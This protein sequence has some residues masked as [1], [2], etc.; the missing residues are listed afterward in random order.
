MAIEQHMMDSIFMQGHRF[1]DLLNYVDY[2]DGIYCL[3]DGSLGKIWVIKPVSCEGREGEFLETLSKNVEQLIKSL[4][5]GQLAC[6]FIVQVCRDTHERQREYQCY[7][8]LGTVDNSFMASKLHHLTGLARD[9]Q[10]LVT[11]RYFPQWNRKSWLGG[12]QNIEFMLKNHQ[13]DF[14][15]IFLHME[16]VLL[17]AQIIAVE[18]NQDQLVHWL[19]RVLNPRRSQLIRQLT[20]SEDVSLRE[21][22]LFNEP[23]VTG[24]GLIVEGQHMRVISLKEL[25]GETQPG[26]F[27]RELYEGLR[28]C[29]LDSAPSMMMVINLTVP[30]ASESINRLNWHKSFAFMHQNNWLGDKSIEVQEKKKELDSTIA[31]L[32]REGERIVHA[33]CHVIIVAPGIDELQKSTDVLINAFS[34]LQC[35]AFVETMIGASLFLTCL[36]LGFDPYYERYI[37]RVKRLTSPNAAD[38]LPFYGS[39]PGTRTPAAIYLNRRGEMVWLDFF[40]SNINPHAVVVGASGAGKS[41]FMN[42]FILQHERLGAHFF[43]LD[44]GDSYRKINEILKG[45]YVRFD[46]NSPVTINPFAHEPT[47]ENLSFLQS[48]LCQMACGGDE[49]DRLSREEEGLLQ[50]AVILTYERH[51]GEII[52]SDVVKTLN[53]SAFNDEFGINSI[54]GPTLA[55]RLTPFTK[56]G[57]YGG[58]F[59]GPNQ[60]EIKGSFTVFE[61]ANLS[62]YSDLQVVV[63]LNLMFFMTNFVSAPAM[64]PLRKY[65]LIDEAWSLL[66]VKNTADFITNAFKTFRKYRCCVTAI[67]Q[68][69][70]DLTRQ[71]SGLAIIANASNKIFLKQEPALID[72]LK[73]KLSFDVPILES[74]KSLET[75]RGKFSEAFV[76]TDE[77]KGVVRLYADPMLYWA[78]NSQ[79]RDNEYLHQQSQQFSGDLLK[80]VEKCAKEYPYGLS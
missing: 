46:L 60:F 68:E 27:T 80:A 61:L 65:L 40:D 31:R 79:A 8:E 23:E 29:V 47:P 1:I 15:K 10:V 14:K 52:L 28:Y 62:S 16:H 63:L 64:R 43:V 20:V 34:R 69:L 13:E 41:F 73:D 37:K 44:K 70:A 5:Q 50:K 75:V 21:Q 38:M 35:Q 76:M 36:P 56:R 18:L 59:D 71:E 48:L 17:S 19:Y 11:I 42:D 72:L 4:P 57:P 2:E 49:R 66:K 53:D 45:N 55:L 24:E 67:T 25:P 78:A 33:R 51:Q 30:P 26:M 74:L 12:E 32:Y 54:M 9:I 7:Q 6:Q 39:F 77:S 3:A 58:F 22:V